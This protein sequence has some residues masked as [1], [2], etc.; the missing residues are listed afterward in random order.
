MKMMVTTR[1]CMGQ[2]E[3]RLCLAQVAFVK[4]IEETKNEKE[5]FVKGHRSR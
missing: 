3:E 1:E 5:E 2:L 4:T